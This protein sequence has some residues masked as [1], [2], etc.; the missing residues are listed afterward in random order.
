VLRSR[1]SYGPFNELLDGATELWMYAPSG[2]N[3]LVR[4][5]ADIRRWLAGGGW[6]RIVVQDP[7]AGSLAALGTQLDDSTD[8]RSTLHTALTQ[9]A[10]LAA[11][12]GI[13][14]RVLGFNP[15]FSLVV[16]NPRGGSGR[17]ILE[18]H[19]FRDESI[20]ERMHIEIR[21]SQSPHWFTY[22]AARFEA[23]WE[24]ASQG[25]GTPTGGGDK[26]WS[27]S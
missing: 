25:L 15:G 6:A 18:L 9:L 23:I 17:L 20:A 11:E 2:V 4:H 16:V 21:R 19:G 14:Y 10:K 13:E 3:V 5:A 24:T 27:S 7:S 12:G 1:D 22:W 26:S 8:F